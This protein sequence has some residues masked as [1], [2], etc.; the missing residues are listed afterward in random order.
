MVTTPSPWA[1]THPRN[2]HSLFRPKFTFTLGFWAEVHDKPNTAGNPTIGGGIQEVDIWAG[3]SKSF[4]PLTVGVTYQNWFYADE[5]EDILDIAFSYDT[6]LSP[7]LTIHQRLD[8][9]AA[10]GFGGDEGTILVLGLE[11][12]FDLGP[13]SL[14]IP[15]SVAYFVDEGFHGPTGDSGIGYGSLGLQASLPLTSL[16]GEAYGDWSLNAGVTYYVTDD[17]VIGGGV[18]PEEDSFLV[19]NIGLSL[20]F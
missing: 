11:H 4:G 8:A 10:K 7:S 19:T 13:V 14:T 5:T 16:I 1:S 17:D 3:V 2:W 20:S 9:G 18:N 15:F 12:G 6:F